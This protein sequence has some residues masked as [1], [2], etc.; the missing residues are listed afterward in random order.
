M[1]AFCFLLGFWIGTAVAFVLLLALYTR[2]E[3]S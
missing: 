1:T 3:G 2:R